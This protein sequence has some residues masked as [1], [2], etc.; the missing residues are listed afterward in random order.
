MVFSSG[1]FGDDVSIDDKDE[2]ALLQEAMDRIISRNTR[3]V[4][5]FRFDF[6]FFFFFFF[7]C[8]ALTPSI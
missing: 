7:F 1:G 6:F 8:A 4:K 5:N 3:E 2:D